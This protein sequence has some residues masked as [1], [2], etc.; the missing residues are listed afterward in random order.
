MIDGSLSI[1]AAMSYAY[2]VGWYDG[3][4]KV[5]SGLGELLWRNTKWPSNV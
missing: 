5:Q 2:D 4:L 3:V 1:V